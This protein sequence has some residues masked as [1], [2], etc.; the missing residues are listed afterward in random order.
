MLVCD[1]L[2][3]KCTLI[4]N[5][6]VC[7]LTIQSLKEYAKMHIG[8]KSIEPETMYLHSESPALFSQ[9]AIANVC[10]LI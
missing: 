8:T 2:K 5:F 10:M 3:I 9:I 1:V 7:S 4:S 6:N